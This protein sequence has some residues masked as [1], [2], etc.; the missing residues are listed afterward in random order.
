MPDK[1][2]GSLPYWALLI[3]LT[4]TFLTGGASRSD[5]Q[6]LVIL[7]P[8]AVLFLAYGLWNMQWQQAMSHRLVFILALGTVLVTLAH[9]VP[10]PPTIWEQ[11]PG[12]ELAAEISRLT[13]KEPVWRPI[14]LVP[15]AT[16]NA[17]YALMIPMAVLIMAIQLEREQK[18]SLLFVLMGFAIVTAVVGFGQSIA[19]GDPLYLYRITNEDSAVG[20]FANRNHQ[21]VLL[22]MLIPM[23]AIYAATAADS[24]EKIRFRILLSIGGGMIIIPLILVTGSRAGL[25]V[26]AIGILS[27]PL[28][29]RKHGNV[30]PPKRKA[31]KTDFRYFIGFGAV[32]ALVLITILMARG[33]AFERMAESGNTEEFRFRMWQPVIQAAW[34]YFPIGSGAGTFVE[35][36]QVHEPKDLLSIYY[37]NH[38]HNDFLE[39]LLTTGLPGVLLTF[40]G[41]AAYVRAA[42][43]AFQSYKSRNREKLYARLGAVLIFMLMIASAADYPLRVPALVSIFVVAV[44]WLA[45]PKMDSSPNVTNARRSIERSET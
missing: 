33:Q 2:W 3:F 17:F 32:I 19:P 6:S 14:S 38:A 20:L 11:L 37:V 12:R 26:G 24:V 31:V 44:V 41:A 27:I 21:A 39:M 18:F 13:L 5:V 43:A 35:V 30:K 23:L 1:K 9:L 22:A 8:A 4:I 45:Y 29:Y 40:V 36:Y 34:T 7:R 28:L 10:L 25:L 15:P 42:W 16:W